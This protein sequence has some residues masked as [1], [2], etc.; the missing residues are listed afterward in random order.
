MASRTLRDWIELRSRLSGTELSP[1]AEQYL[2]LLSSPKD[3]GMTARQRWAWE[4]YQPML[5]AAAER[6]SRRGRSGLTG[7]GR[8]TDVPEAPIV[9]LNRCK[10]R[11]R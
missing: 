9:S 2:D 10:G 1:R 11:K 4:Q 5:D 3:D 7:L 8:F 6:D